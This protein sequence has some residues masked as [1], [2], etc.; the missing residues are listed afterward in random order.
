MMSLTGASRAVVPAPA[1]CPA[2]LFADPG[3]PAG[4][5][6]A[7]AVDGTGAGAAI[8]DPDAALPELAELPEHP[9]SNIPP[10]SMRPPIARP[11][12]APDRR[13]AGRRFKLSMFSMPL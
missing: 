8:P 4:P 7:A 11:A 5:A 1:G 13:R 9:A 12:A 6:A 10:A 2:K 3:T